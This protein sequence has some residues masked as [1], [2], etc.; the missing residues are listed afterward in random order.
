MTTK[1]L[2]QLKQ[3]A[4]KNKVD[5][6]F[7]YRDYL[8]QIYLTVK[9]KDQGYSWLKFASDL[10]FSATNVVR[11]IV[12]GKRHLPSEAAEQVGTHLGLANHERRYFLNLVAYNE[13][14][15]SAEQEQS[16]GRL[17]ASKQ[18]LLDSSP[19]SQ[20]L[21]YYS[22]WY[23]PVIRE[24]TR[25]GGFQATFEW[26]SRHLF[27]SLRPA[28]FNEG[29]ELLR[30]MKLLEVEPV[31]GIVKFLDNRQMVLPTD[32]T[33]GNIAISQYH[34][35]MLEVAAE[36]VFK[37]PDSDREMN[38]LTLCLSDE[39]FAKLKQRI[40]DVC[41]EAMQTESEPQARERL[42]QLNVQLFTLS[43]K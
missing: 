29:I 8:K 15:T 36:A 7:D 28:Q 11:L 25:L 43:K 16:L 42:V 1:P 39:S 34:R 38:A 20:A 22:K 17:V 3:A 33:A 19:D 6:F 21:R 23:F 24:M 35:K 10:G 12:I 14:H 5:T 9:A 2:A 27:P 40:L 30:E 18:A 13:A 31:T 26:V 41:A 37:I 32:A 4:A